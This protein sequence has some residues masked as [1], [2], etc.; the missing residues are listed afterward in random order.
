M[1]S[2]SELYDKIETCKMSLFAARVGEN[3]P[4]LLSDLVLHFG[5]QKSKKVSVYT[6]ENSFWFQSHVTAHLY[7]TKS[8]ALDTYLNPCLY[9]YREDK[10]DGKKILECLEILRKS[11]ISIEPLEYKDDYVDFILTN[12][13]K[14][15]SDVVMIYQ[16]DSL[17][18]K[19]KRS[20]KEVLDEFCKLRD[21]T[22]VILVSGV[23]RSV[24]ETGEYTWENVHYFK[25]IEP[26][27]QECVLMHI[28]R[29]YTS[30][31]EK[32][33]I[34]ETK[35]TSFKVIYNVETDRFR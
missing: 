28:K 20:P 18:G 23:N 24:E 14:N 33:E 29:P 26:Y 11:D 19:G 5:L 10:L 17:F 8:Y 2:L 7:G 15:P 30:D 27:V 32:M 34:I 3:M 13:R 1:K 31:E 22:R 25:E 12:E 9:Y 35:D 4:S 16:I 21:E 6:L